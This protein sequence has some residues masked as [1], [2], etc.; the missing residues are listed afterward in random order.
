MLTFF[1]K[2]V[3]IFIST[4]LMF[5]HLFIYSSCPQTILYLYSYI[6][7]YSC[8]IFADAPART[9]LYFSLF[10]SSSYSQLQ[11]VATTVIIIIYDTVFK[12]WEKEPTALFRRED[13]KQPTEVYQKIAVFIFQLRTF[14]EVEVQK[15]YFLEQWSSQLGHH[16]RRFA[17]ERTYIFLKEQ[18][19]LGC[20]CSYC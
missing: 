13:K 3:C 12:W 6:L 15:L 1:L 14:R 20:S 2:T 10:F 17:K 7:T 5:Y 16:R 8:V 11:L 19:V 4:L 9:Q 18:G